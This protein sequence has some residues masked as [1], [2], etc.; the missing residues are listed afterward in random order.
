MAASMEDITSGI[1]HGNLNPNYCATFT[2][3]FSD[4]KVSIVMKDFF[5]YIDDYTTSIICQPDYLNS[6]PEQEEVKPCLPRGFFYYWGAIN[7]C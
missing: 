2:A 4:E 5:A 1:I 7:I 3:E 6:S